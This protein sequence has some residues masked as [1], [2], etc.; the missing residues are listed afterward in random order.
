MLYDPGPPYRTL[1][2][3]LGGIE[4]RVRELERH[5]YQMCMVYRHSQIAI[6]SSTLS[7]IPWNSAPINDGN[8]WSASN[9]GNVII[10]KTGIWQLEVIGYWQSS[11]SGQQR[12]GRIDGSVSGIQI[13]QNVPVGGSTTNISVNLSTRRLLQAG[14]GVALLVFQDSGANLDFGIF[15]ASNSPN[16]SMSVSWIRGA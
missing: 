9:P 5:D 14:E 7:G 2:D 12:T 11:G 15:A 6:A 3:E 8:M 13:S 1:T 4:Y 10:P 16:C